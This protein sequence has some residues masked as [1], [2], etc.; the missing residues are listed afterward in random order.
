M[1]EKAMETFWRYGYQG[2]SIQNLLENMGINRGSLYDTFGNKRSLFL[3][4]IAHYDETV[5]KDAIARLEAPNASKQA[6][7]DHFYRLIDLAVA[8]REHRGCLLT[9]TA[10]ELCAHDPETATLIGRDLQR[11]ENA[12]YKALVRAKEKGELPEKPNLRALARFLTCSL[13]G[14]R[15]TAKVNPDRGVLREIAQ[16]VLSVLDFKD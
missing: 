6:I 7:I 3:A 4:A 16:V 11:I 9:N 5:V 13:Q 15:V 14:L 2:T 8:D 12:F 1:L 10:V